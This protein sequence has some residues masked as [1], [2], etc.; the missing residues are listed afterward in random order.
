MH[1]RFDL[2]FFLQE[3]RFSFNSSLV[4]GHI[5]LRLFAFAYRASWTRSLFTRS[6]CSGLGCET[7]AVQRRQLCFRE[8]QKNVFF[9]QAGLRGLK[10]IEPQIKRAIS[11]NLVPGS[12]GNESNDEAEPEHR[13]SPIACV[14]V[15]V[16]R[17]T[18][19]RVFFL[20]RV[21]DCANPINWNCQM[22]KKLT[23]NSAWP[24]RS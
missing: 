15:A 13:V 5:G 3:S 9:R 16:S 4:F 23:S 7:A 19:V 10:D 8:K 22:E 17:T 24:D 6:I 18:G 14:V 2:P 20:Y 1:N 21:H 11:G 12:E